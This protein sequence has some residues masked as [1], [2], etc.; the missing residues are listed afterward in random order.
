MNCEP[1]KICRICLCS[2]DT[3][4]PTEMISPCACKGTMRYV[5]SRCLKK[6]WY[7]DS[8]IPRCDRCEQCLEKY[9]ITPD[10]LS[11][12]SFIHV[13]TLVSLVGAYF[14]TYFVASPVIESLF[15]IFDLFDNYNDLRYYLLPY[16]TLFFLIF[17]LFTGI[18]LWFFFNFLFT[19]WRVM[20]FNF[21]IDQLLYAVSIILFVIEMYSWA[22]S[23]M[24]RYYFILFVR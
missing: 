4:G 15:L 20:F 14:I 9:N 21:I 2:D 3:S 7:H 17:K 13:A 19:F 5:H 22:Y 11:S 24:D 1:D 6:W 12:C 18:R 16:V 23:H 8:F 10:S